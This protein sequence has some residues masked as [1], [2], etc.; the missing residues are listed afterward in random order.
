MKKI[1]SL[2]FVFG[3]A[4]GLAKADDFTGKVATI[5]RAT[6]LSTDTW[7]ALYDN[8]AKTF[9][10]DDGSGTLTTSTTPALNNASEYTGVFFKLESTGN[11]YYMVSG[12]GNYVDAIG[13]G[14]VTTG[15][16]AS[17]AYTFTEAG[18]SS[19]TTFTLQNNGQYLAISGTEAQ[20]GST[21]TEWTVYAV[22]LNSQSDLTAS[23]NKSY[24]TKQLA[25]S[26]G[27]LLRFVN[28]RTSTSYLTGGS[29]SNT[30]SKLK[31]STELSQI[32]Y[33]VTD[34]D[35]YKIRNA[36]TGLFLSDDYSEPSSSSTTLYIQYSPNNGDSESYYNVSSDDE[37]SGSTCLNLGNDG[38][39]LHEWTYSG[40]SGCDW[41]IE[42]VYEV[43]IDEVRDNILASSE[44]VGELQEGVY[45]KIISR[46]YGTAI[47]DDG[48]SMTCQ[49]L[50]DSKVNQVWTLTKSGSGYQFKNVVTENYIQKTSFNTAY[51]TTS[52]ANVMYP[53]RTDD[54]WTYE[55]YITDANN[56][57]N[58]MHCAASTV[59]LQ[60][61]TSANASIWMFQEVE[62]TEEQIEAA[63]QDMADYEA[64]VANVSNIQ[65]A[66]D[67]IFT[68]KA[69]TTLSDTYASMSDEQLAT[70][71]NYNVLNDVLKNMVLKIKN[72]TW[73]YQA[74]TATTA[75]PDGNYEKFFRI[76]NYMPYSHYSKMASE[77]G[78]SNSYGRLSNPTGIY[79]TGGDIAYI[80]V[81]E[82][83]PSGTT[84]MV[85]ALT[86]NADN[87][88]GNST[89]TQTTL[90]K[91]LNLLKYTQDKILFIF[92]QVDNISK[93]VT[94][95]DDMK[96]HIEGGEV[97]GTFDT[98][99]GMTNQ[100]W[101]NMTNA[102]LVTNYG[103]MNLKGDN[104]VMI[105]NRE[106]A[107]EAIE[108]AR[109]S[110]GTSYQDMELLL[111][112]WNTIVANEE[113][114]Q[115]LYEWGDRYRNIWNAYSVNSNYMYASTYG[116]YYNNSTLSTVLNYYSM[117]HDA[118]S[119]W[120]PSHEFGHNHQ[121]LINCKGNMEVSNN[122]FSNINVF[123]SGISSTRGYAPSTNFENLANG[124][125][126]L[127][128]DIWTRTR[129]YF[130]LYLYFVEQGV[131]TLFFQKLFAE[132][133]DD[134]MTTSGTSQS[135]T[136]DGET[137]SGTA[138]S[139]ADDYLKFAK[140]C[141]DV[142]GMDLSEYFE[143]Y[144]FF[145]PVDAY[146]IEDY[147]NYVF[148][149][150]ETE[151]RS[152][153]R[154]MQKYE[155]KA[156]NIMFINDYAVQHEA[157]YDNKF[158]A[159]PASNGMR[160]AYNISYGT[161]VTTGDFKD[162]NRTEDYEVTGD[163]YTI[164]GSTITFKGDNYLGH[165]IYDLDGNLI[166]AVANKSET[167]P[168]AIKGLFPDSV[169]VVAAEP[170]LED[171][172]C[173]YYK[174]GGVST[175]YKMEVTFPTGT[176]NIWYANKNFDEYMPTN[177]V[178]VVTANNEANDDVLSTTNVV[179][180]AG[181][182]EQLVIDGDLA[183]VIPSDFTATSLTFTK[184]GEG[185]QA[186]QLPFAVDA[187][188]IVD[189]ERVKNGIVEAGKPVVVEGEASFTLSN[190]AVTAGSFQEKESGYVLSSDGKSTVAATE[191]SPFT[192]TFD[193]VADIT[194]ATAINNILSQPD[195]Q[196]QTV[197][198]LNGRRVGSVRKSGVYVI[199]GKKTLVK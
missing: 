25:K 29:S 118:G 165:K 57:T 171:I 61:Y 172:P 94:D 27:V 146:L 49:D 103:I 88:G 44:Y 144:G 60:W 71:E 183:M 97:F 64:L 159:V 99:R 38:S 90:T 86:A 195:A 127:D 168:T 15:S 18:T 78:Q 46:S 37:F 45:Y 191:I 58:G 148:T 128:R 151:I 19:A 135:V 98:T 1:L 85:E 142:A 187:T 23:Q 43:T 36:S 150:T 17:A 119:L 56:G 102:G 52:T 109:S 14:A 108:A 163:Y 73:S 111:H 198:D 157:D 190:T 182:A 20:G 156:G 83:A 124:D 131:D 8:T 66:L 141:C 104:I 13:D 76:N 185:Y 105:M 186:L 140:K 143:A 80:F 67:V 77:V 167:I 48:G 112:V 65:A 154:Y 138:L 145:V 133:R 161:D 92:Y 153:K 5:S 174:N 55:W 158:K 7:Y 122:L 166:W 39:T 21:S 132:L 130:Q 114:Y 176:T 3:C 74:T 11:D 126:W 194:T 93:N 96:V 134:P 179:S 149:T 59:V 69:C 117:T 184:S 68:D 63:K 54:E 123:E 95:Y 89:G 24:I 28:K 42:V 136:V 87:C 10:N 106:Y 84:F 115:G 162:Y 110:Y 160:S 181:V 91:G 120:G 50:S 101:A 129:M 199:N 81:D 164:S 62:V 51:P 40:D 26:E 113:Y 188:T 155:K 22:T 32:W 192:Y 107:W 137:K 82:D 30:G 147:S 53:R 16:S 175:V 189:N 193:E 9:L 31:S 180:K 4:I 41:K 169:V 6:S 2:L 196:E 75:V 139:G 70:D 35:G 100:D 72:D 79:L 47:T 177:A 152:A 34:D 33:A 121:S 173:H 12:R 170:N 116:T 178:A 125:F 197:Y